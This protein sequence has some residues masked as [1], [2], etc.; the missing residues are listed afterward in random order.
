MEY[1][2]NNEEAAELLNEC[3]E[4]M[5]LMQ[6][7]HEIEADMM[8]TT[9]LQ[10]VREHEMAMKRM[11]KE[12]TRQLRNKQGKGKCIGGGS[13]DTVSSIERASSQS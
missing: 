11:A 2:N 12:H 1:Q 6:E 8:S 7:E 9:H 10:L 13:W 5:K 3:K 4:E